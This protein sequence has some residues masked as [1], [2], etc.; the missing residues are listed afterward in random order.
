MTVGLLALLLAAILAWAV[1]LAAPSRTVVQVTLTADGAVARVNDDRLTLKLAPTE[2]AAGGH[3]GW[4]LAAPRDSLY[5]TPANSQ[6]PLVSWGRLGEALQL[7]RPRAHWTALPAPAPLGASKEAPGGTYQPTAWQILYGDPAGSAATAAV[8]PT[9]RNVPDARFYAE[10]VGGRVPA[11]L[12]IHMDEAQDGYAFIIRPER[13]NTGWW[14]VSHGVPTTLID[15]DVYRPSFWAGLSDLVQELAIALTGALLLVA[16]VGGPAL[17]ARVLLRRGLAPVAA[18]ALATDPVD[19]PV[20]ASWRHWL[21]ALGFG[22][23]GTVV[24]AAICLGPLQG[25][26]HVQDDVAYVWQ[27][28]IFALARAWVPA[29]PRPYFFEQGFIL[30]TDGRWFT[31][32]PPGWPLL[33]VP[34]VWAGIPWIVD[35]L[36]AGG[37]LALVYATGRRLY[38]PAAGFWAALLG[39]TSPFLMFMAGSFMSHTS[40]MFFLMLAVYCFV[41]LKTAPPAPAAARPMLGL[42]WRTVLLSLGTGFGLSWAFISR[43]ATALGVALP[44]FAWSLADIA[45]GVW[46]WL[47]AR[48]AVPGGTRQLITCVAPYALMVAGALPPL[49]VLGVVNQALL[50]SP[51]KLAQELVGSYDRL[52]FGPGFGPEPAGH[53]PALGLYNALVYLRTLQGDLFGWPPTLALAPL[54][55]ALAG[56]VGSRWRRARWDLFLLGGFLGLVAIYF[57]WWSSTTIYGARYW[58]EGLPFL[59]LLSGR[60]VQLLGRGVGVLLAAYSDGQQAG[61]KP[62]PTAQPGQQA[63][64]K[65]APPPQDH[66]EGLPGRAVLGGRRAAWAALAVPALAVSLLIVFNLAQVMPGQVRAY[67]GY[68]DVD[69]SALQRVEA[70]HLDHAVVFVALNPAFPRRDYGKVFFANDPLLRGPVVYVRDVGAGGNAALLPSFPDRQPYYLPLDGPLQPGTGP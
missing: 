39:L 9:S 6:A 57:A 27:A 32:Y 61:L 43:E 56:T 34:G 14:R 50:G 67:T 33:L 52:G 26:P 51:F 4:Y 13:R 59:L 17:L 49:V 40:T 55:I 45:G 1:A 16:V 30:I 3:F 68:N 31:K 37:T 24:A 42:D 44:F 29:P 64:L 46:A 20:A 7:A 70:A 60:G 47:R 28:K 35:P 23:A 41:W 15:G 10:L 22:V 65:P 18:L 62:A 25:I 11:G 36:C 5:Y 8:D 48:R 54:L 53:T 63:G 21:P 58:Y 38:G 19:P 69:A 2:A 66:S 12:F